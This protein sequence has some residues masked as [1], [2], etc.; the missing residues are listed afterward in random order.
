LSRLNQDKVQYKRY[1]L[2]AMSVLAL[3]GMAVSADLTLVGKDLIRILLGPKWDMAGQIFTFFGPGIGIMLVY[4]TH[5]WLHLSI[6]TSERWLRWGFIEVGVTALLFLIALPWGPVGMAVAW[7]VSYWILTIPAFWYAGKPIDLGMGSV[8][9]AIWKFTLAA[10]L[11]GGATA[12][13]V[14]QFPALAAAPGSAGAW[15]RLVLTS[16]MF[17]VL[18]LAMVILLHGGYAPI[19]Q[20]LNLLR[21]MIPWGK[22]RPTATSAEE[23]QNATSTLS[24]E[25]IALSEGVNK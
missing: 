8:V 24:P 22:L 14:R 7:A 25:Q 4:Y 20:L 1:F 19:R 23:V 16:L 18:Y 13:L 12:A 3:V 15:L 9:T 21:E 11:A 6:G 2:T 10:L 5:G 17:G